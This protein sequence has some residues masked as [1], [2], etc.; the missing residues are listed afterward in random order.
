MEQR[1]NLKRQCAGPEWRGTAANYGPMEASV[2]GITQLR[3]LLSAFNWRIGA[4]KLFVS[5]YFAPRVAVNQS[6]RSSAHVG[7]SMARMIAP[8]GAQLSLIAEN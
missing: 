6:I 7:G 5:M 8:R 2:S 3:S 4:N 1:R